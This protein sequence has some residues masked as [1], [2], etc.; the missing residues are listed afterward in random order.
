MTRKYD[1]VHNY[2]FLLDSAGTLVADVSPAFSLCVSWS[3][4]PRGI[5]KQFNDETIHVKQSSLR[6]EITY[7][8]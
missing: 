6:T 8:L 5:K 4:G 2:H 7:H 1:L 3:W